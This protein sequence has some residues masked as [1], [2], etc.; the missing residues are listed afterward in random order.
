[1]ATEPNWEIGWNSFW[2]TRVVEEYICNVVLMNHCVRHFSQVHSKQVP[3]M[4][5]GRCV[6]WKLVLRLYTGLT[7]ASWTNGP[8][9]LDLSTFC[10]HCFFTSSLPPSS[11]LLELPPRWTLSC[12]AT[13]TT[14]FWTDEKWKIWRSS[15]IETLDNTSCRSTSAMC[16]CWTIAFAIFH[17]YKANTYPS[18]APVVVSDGN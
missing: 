6:R 16:S 17:R 9:S 3:C 11:Q 14:S 18:C 2:K 12:K 8:S 4:C 7:L 5:P 10:Q 1:M 15:P 13:S